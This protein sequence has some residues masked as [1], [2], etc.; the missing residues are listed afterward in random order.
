MCSVKQKNILQQYIWNR[1]SFLFVKS[2]GV[3]MKIMGIS[4]KVVGMYYLCT[5]NFQSQCTTFWLE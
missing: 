4:T 5:K 1:L 2:T 3:Y